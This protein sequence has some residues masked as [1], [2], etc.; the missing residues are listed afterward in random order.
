[1][2]LLANAKRVVPLADIV[3]D[4][5]DTVLTSVPIVT[6]AEVIL[7]LAGVP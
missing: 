7:G 5:F 3:L 4:G 6:V 2:C 1:M